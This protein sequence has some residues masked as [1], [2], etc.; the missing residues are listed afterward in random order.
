MRASERARRSVL[1]KSA[2]ANGEP[3]AAM[4]RT[5]VHAHDHERRRE[6]VDGVEVRERG[7]R[8]LGRAGHREDQPDAEDGGGGSAGP[9]TNTARARGDVRSQMAEFLVRGSLPDRRVGRATRAGRTSPGSR[10]RPAAD[11][12]S[13]RSCRL[14]PRGAPR[15]APRVFTHPAR[16]RVRWGFF[17]P[18][19]TPAPGWTSRWSP[20][21]G[22][23]AASRRCFVRAA[24]SPRTSP[25]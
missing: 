3:A 1:N 17:P 7:R 25:S 13:T 5:G 15:R 11:R 8:K 6:D 23:G 2:R 18:R 10:P 14:V 21:L 20:G 16:A 4:N 12:F 22:S 9:I 19:L 24:P